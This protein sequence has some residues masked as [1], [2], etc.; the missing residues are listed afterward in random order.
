M[1]KHHIRRNEKIP[2]E[3]GPQ[4][5]MVIPIKIV[6]KLQTDGTKWPIKQN[7]MAYHLQV[8]LDINVSV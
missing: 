1:W 6:K 7:F 2:R 5:I 3:T 4:Q 8:Q